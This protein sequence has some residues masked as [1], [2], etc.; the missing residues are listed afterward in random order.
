MSTISQ[1]IPE[2]EKSLDEVETWKN[3]YIIQDKPIHNTKWFRPSCWG[4][5]Y[6]QI[7]NNMKLLEFSK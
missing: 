2:K 4:P 7:Y 5:V 6:Y 1:H 3:L